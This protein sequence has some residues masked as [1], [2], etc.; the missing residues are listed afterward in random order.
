MLDLQ[1]AFNTIDHEIL[2]QKLS[3]ISTIRVVSVECFHLYLSNKIQMVN[4]KSTSS[5]FQIIARG[6]P[7]EASWANCIFSAIIDMSVSISF[8]FTVYPFFSTLNI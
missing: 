5:D 2:R 6:M 7:Q 1:T 8:Y 4:V 3:T